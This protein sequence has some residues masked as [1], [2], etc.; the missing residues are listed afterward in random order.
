[1]KNR[2][3]ITGVGLLPLVVACGPDNVLNPAGESLG[4]VKAPPS[5]SVELQ[6]VSDASLALGFEE[7]KTIEAKLTYDNGE[8]AGGRPVTFRLEGEPAGA[9]LQ[10]NRVTSEPDGSVTNTVTA[11]IDITT[12]S[13]EISTLQPEGAEKPDPA[14]TV[15]VSVDGVY[16]G[17]LRVTYAYNDVVPLADVRTRVH[18]G[19]TACEDIVWP[20]QP[21]GLHEGM[22]ATPEHTVVFSGL[23]AQQRYTVSAL[24]YGPGGG[25]AATG[26]AQTEPLERR[27]L[28]VVSVPLTLEPVQLAGR[29]DFGAQ[30]Q[31][32][33]ALPPP[34]D[35]VVERLDAFFFDPAGILAGY[36]V[37][38]VAQATG[39]APD[40]ISG[41]LVA[42]WSVYALGQELEPDLDADDQ[43][44]DDPIDY[45]LLDNM[46]AWAL[47][48][49]TIGGDLTT[50]LAR[51]AVGGTFEISGVD[52]SGAFNGRWDWS[53]FM[54]TWRVG[55]DCDPS[56][57]CCGRRVFDGDA[58]GLAP[59]GAEFTGTLSRND[60]DAAVAY[61]MDVAPH[62]LALQYGTLVLFL[63]EE[64][65]LPGT[66]GQ[67]NL[68]CA[69]ESLFGCEPGGGSF[70]CGG[71]STGVCG[72]ERVGGWLSDL[73]NGW[74]NAQVSP[75]VGAQA[76]QVA[77]DLGTQYLED[78]LAE[79]TYNGTDSTYL[80][81]GLSDGRL[82][83][84]DQDLRA[85]TWNG[86]IDGDI[87]INNASNAFS[88]EAWGEL[89][90][91]SCGTD[92]DCPAGLACESRPGLLDDCRLRGVCSL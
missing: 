68:S 66:T 67:P 14:V 23:E 74:V 22:A 48:G 70:V 73:L 34:A 4:G 6:L 13:I 55:A 46:P 9:V 15:P 79:L 62:A 24:V 25:I 47:D 10:S 56:N 51:T 35:D 83:D 17:D 20:H 57:A 7:S 21:E 28:N 86:A 12:F 38:G 44:I 18:S 60:L 71:Q 49:I 26:C 39:V 33:D 30:L 75:A 8:P 32:H 36:L 69:V 77:V 76:C 52:A 53:D 27:T 81:M 72:C 5:R 50:L 84:A 64:L 87:V 85:D 40:T 29:Y 89:Q 90:L 16:R 2:T 78:T 43:Y 88:G 63:L 65:V 91:P 37:D 1:M 80:E 61:D 92:A 19:A 41:A 3:K 45:F 58:V 42:A 11:G 31:L 82:T 59:A 54:F